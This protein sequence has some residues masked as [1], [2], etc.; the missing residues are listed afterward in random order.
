MLRKPFLLALGSVLV[1]AG[2]AAAQPAPLWHLP[3]AYNPL[4]PV[5]PNAL[6][7]P[8]PC[9][10]PFCPSSGPPLLTLRGEY[11]LWALKPAPTPPLLTTS[12]PSDLGVLGGSTTTLRF[13]G[14]DT[15]Y[16]PVSGGRITAD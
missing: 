8:R 10:P 15:V 5:P 14:N 7:E 11:L 3:S 4:A 2:L 1:C 9:L 13:G 12:G 6:P 16:G